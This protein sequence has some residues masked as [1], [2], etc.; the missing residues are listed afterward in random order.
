MSRVRRRSN[1]RDVVEAF[2]AHLRDHGHPALRVERRPDEENPGVRDVDA[3]AGAF[4]IEHTSIDTLPNQRRDS[5]WFMRVAGNLEQELDTTPPFRLNIT[6]QWN[7]IT[8]GQN[9]AAIRAA[10]KKWV[11]NEAPRLADGRHV[12]ESLPGIPFR[13]HVAKSS[14][15]PP[16]VFFARF[17]P[18]DD[19]FPL[20]VNAAFNGKAEKLAKYKPLGRTTILLVENNDIAIMNESKMIEAIRTAFPAGLPAAVDQV[21]YADTSIESAVEFQDFTPELR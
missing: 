16:G 2:V 11:T 6:L 20:R 14:K 19:T 7:A 1:D 17:P 4:A 9:W 10:L 5:D 13:L 8:T 21:W 3:I 15:R 12:I 18:S